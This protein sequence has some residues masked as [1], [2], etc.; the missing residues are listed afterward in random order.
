MR[1]IR[2]LLVDDEP[3]ALELLGKYASMIE[4]LTVVGISLSAVKAFDILNKE[5]VDLMFLDI[6]MPV[7]NGIDFLKTLQ[8]PPAIILTTAYREYA[9]DGYDLDIIDYLLKP[10]PFERF[11]KAIERFKARR[12]ASVAPATQVE[13]TLTFFFCK[14]N[15]SQHKVFFDQILYVESLKDYVRIHT[16]KEKLVVKGNLGAYMRI[17]P[18]Q[19]FTRVHRSF[20][21]ANQHITAYNQH[22]VSIGEIKIPIGASYREA[23][24]QRMVQGQN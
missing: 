1:K 7:L 22:R 11:L 2:C 12:S 5:K 15:R 16:T 20:T 6:Q 4:Q 23:F 21:V 13:E 8:H 3:P 24:Q 17:L 14:V 9:L 10:I 18:P 19:Q